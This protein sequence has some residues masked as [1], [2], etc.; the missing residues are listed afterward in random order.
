[1][2]LR[3]TGIQVDDGKACE[4]ASRVTE[5]RKGSSS[6][7]GSCG[8]QSSASLC[9]CGAQNGAS[10]PEGVETPACRCRSLQEFYVQATRASKPDRLTH[11]QSAALIESW[12][13]FGVRLDDQEVVVEQH[14]RI[15]AQA[16]P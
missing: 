12:L 1:M 15:E 11:E 9:F 5:S 4:L 16:A 13:R 14:A 3:K 7:P 8:G 2:T 10:R 6:P